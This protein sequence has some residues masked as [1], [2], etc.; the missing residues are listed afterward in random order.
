MAGG[1]A[2]GSCE[3]GMAKTVAAL[4]LLL[5]ALLE[6]ALAQHRGAF[7]LVTGH[8]GYNG[9]REALITTQLLASF[10]NGITYWWTDFA[11][12]GTISLGGEGSASAGA[13]RFRPL[14]R[15]DGAHSYLPPG[16]VVES[17]E[18]SFTVV[19]WQ[20]AVLAEACF[21]TRPWAHALLPGQDRFKSTGWLYAR[22]APNTSTPEPWTAAGG[23]ADCTAAPSLAA[24]VPAG[25]REGYWVQ[26]LA[27]DPGR[28]AA[29]LVDGGAANYGLIFRSNGTGSLVSSWW[30]NG[31]MY[32]P[33]LRVNYVIPPPYSNGTARP[34]VQP[35][36]RT[37][38]AV[39]WAGSRTWWVSPSGSDETGSGHPQLPLRS[40]AKALTVAQPGD[41]I[42]LRGGTYPGVISIS[43]PR[44]TL[45]SAPGH[46]ATLTARLSDP[47]DAVN[48]V[49]LLPGADGGVLQ[50]LAITGGHYYGLN[51]FSDGAVT[52][53][54]WVVRNV[55]IH[56]TGSS[57][58]KL[59]MGAA[60]NTFERCE[61]FD[62]GARMRTYGYGIDAVR[63]YDLHVRDCFFHDLPGAALILSG[64]S[65]RATF[66][67]NMVSRCDRGV[68]VGSITDPGLMDKVAN[69]Q[70]YEA[71]NATLHNNIFTAIGQAGV[72]LRAASGAV[73]SHN[74]LYGVQE[75]GQAAVLLDSAPH[76]GS[77][78]PTP[79][80]GPVV[81][82]ANV[83][84]R[85][86]EAR[87]GPLFQI[88]SGGLDNSSSSTLIMS[89]NRYW[90][91]AGPGNTT[92]GA[93]KWGLGPMLEDQR[94][95]SAFTGNASGW[96]AHCAVRLGQAMCDPGSSADSD[97]GLDPGFEPLRCG[98]SAARA[99]ADPAT[100]APASLPAAALARLAAAAVVED[101][102]GRQRPTDNGLYDI[103][104]VQYVADGQAHVP[105]KPLP[106]PVPSAF[107]HKRP[108]AGWG[109]VRDPVYE[110]V[111]PF[112]F[113]LPRRSQDIWVDAVGGTD[114][115]AFDYYANYSRPFRTLQRA[116]DRAG[117][118]DRIW[119]YGNQT[120]A[121]PVS[122]KGTNIS[123]ATRPAD[124]AE[125]RRALLRCAGAG[126]GAAACVG[127]WEGATAVQLSGFDVEM[128]PG[129]AG[130][131]VQANAG[132]GSGTSAYWRWWLRASNRTAPGADWSTFADLRLS[133]CGTHGLKLSTFVSRVRIE[134]TTITRPN[135]TGI[136][137]VGGNKIRIRGNTVLS[138]AGSCFRAGGG[139]RDLVLE[140]NLGRD[141]GGVGIF[142]GSEE[143]SPALGDADWA[144]N[145]RT[146]EPGSPLPGAS[147]LLAGDWHDA[148]RVIAR[149]NVIQGAAGAGLA[150]YSAREVQALHNTLL[151]VA[152]SFHA[153]ILLN[154]SPKQV[155][156]TAQVGPPNT[157]IALR[158]NIIQ[159]AA[160]R[161]GAGAGRRPAV[162][163]RLLQG[164]I[165]NRQLLVQPPNG[166][167]DP[168]PPTANGTA[169]AAGAG[170]GR[171]RQLLLGEGRG[172]HP[173][174]AGGDG[175]EGAEGQEE[176]E[177]VGAGAGVRVG[178]GEIAPRRSLVGLS[179]TAP[180]YA[181]SREQGRNADGSCPMYPDSHFWNQDVSAL[182]VHPRSE[183]IKSNIG[184]GSLHLDFGF[185][186]TIGGRQVPAG[187]FINLVDSTTWP[188]AQI[189]FGPDGYPDESVLEP[190][191]LPI[192]ADA[193]VQGS[194]PGCGDPPCGGDRHLIVL[195]NATC[196]L[197]EAWRSF[198]PSVTNASHWQVD[199]LARF[200]LSRARLE[201]PL[202]ATSADAAGLAMLPGLVRYK[203]VAVDG[204]I[205]H[206]IRFTGPNSRPAYSLPAT[207][208]APAGY[209]GR[210]APWMGM[211]VRLRSTYDCAVHTR[212][213]AVL[214]RALQTYGAVFADNGLP[215]DFAGEATPLWHGV[216]E[217]LK[218]AQRIP[219]SAFE[220]LDPG[221]LCLTY[222]CT[223]AECNGGAWSDPDAPATFPALTASSN[224]S[225]SHNLYY[226][227]PPAP[228]NATANG[229]AA[230]GDPGPPP[231]ALFVDQRVPPFAPGYS[232]DLAGWRSYLSDPL[233]GGATGSGN[234]T[235]TN[236]KSNNA[237]DAELG[238]MEAAPLLHAGDFRPLRDSPAR[239]AA[240][241]LEIAAWDF[242]GRNRNGNVTDIGACIGYSG[243][244]P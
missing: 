139:V 97:P 180:Y 80:G 149:S 62:A 10:P 40:P 151:D 168:A 104:A 243:R 110:R 190:A 224:L 68:E 211:R 210:D 135:G 213:A 142:I 127:L 118:G 164:T 113:W 52:P 69:P 32:R 28:V 189:V 29:W 227:P 170:A 34:A 65:S 75:Y 216:Y 4:L 187:M 100:A 33:A 141:C 78:V 82:W 50:N 47:R 147:P 7:L 217:D 219:S 44:I 67:R 130:P 235:T 159:L 103:G 83:I 137:V 136:E 95:G 76:Y 163:A 223:V 77:A 173:H 161:P 202:G 129:A 225:L 49:T 218:D 144:R 169:P 66:E 156:P 194:Y 185:N 195:D 175:T 143:S 206:A 172:T 119:L 90:D 31:T 131:C 152:A 98:P 17:A 192:T 112:Y 20:A 89:Y 70:L 58:V 25:G 158:A 111:W 191:G 48:V 229:P 244:T 59:T 13:V 148:V 209:T 45:Q 121:G 157:N 208:F 182:A 99:P 81:L 233:T 188:R 134:N 145:A 2:H 232:G 120:H 155:G 207:H 126:A 86:A 108:A 11:A 92:G 39:L 115:Q 24:R 226:Q 37:S 46:W 8:N 56:S 93:F 197:W 186:T 96:A 73:V 153:G 241:Q 122:V 16:A 27:L 176:V 138:P 204:V 107:A 240:P 26:T 242:Y 51:F 53:S 133:N 30:A 6:A 94:P 154:V 116:L 91:L 114:D 179:F 193:L 198:P 43:R 238:S 19:N 84:V 12:G 21:L 54:H 55:R 15:F 5:A 167:C 105:S 140:R 102:H 214:C 184:P 181:D 128:G 160:P 3:T 72:L 35:G 166:T 205:R 101:F 23:W 64:G 79:C 60:N 203:E 87:P 228:L 85:S 183:A 236:N 38:P 146:R 132:A 230:Q 36:V 106:D 42:W 196:T 162:Q 74:T 222:G 57:C 239:R 9:T 117:M 1:K 125:G 212:A 201:R 215:W 124:L 165:V 22:A 61:L 41:S 123:V 231:A 221:C 178:A 174:L 14:L 150:L 171:R 234:A 237:P 109:L 63:T 18:L 71:I 88:R 220:V 177:E 200:N 199:A